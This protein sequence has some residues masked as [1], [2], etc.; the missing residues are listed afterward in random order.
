MAAPE[1]RVFYPD[2]DILSV[3]DQALLA[4]S[5]ES[6][7]TGRVKWEEI[8]RTS[9]DCF[10]AGFLYLAGSIQDQDLR[11]IG[12]VAWNALMQERVVLIV[13]SDQGQVLVNLGINPAIASVLALHD[14]EPRLVYNKR[15]R[16]RLLVEEM[17][18][19]V[20]TPAFIDAA[21]TRPVEALAQLT[22][23][24][25]NIRDIVHN[26]VQ[27]ASEATNARAQAA[28]AHFLRYAIHRHPEVSSTLSPNS[29]LAME[30]YPRGLVS[31]A[32]GMRYRGGSGQ[33]YRG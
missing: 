29:L 18:A 21:R 11:Q 20:A 26:R 9:R 17:A 5:S 16:G 19:V 14:S 22:A 31:L 30:T 3:F 24:S 15:S 4:R 33:I 27:D 2:D 1:E 28:R 25:S 23:L 12:T 6:L 32:A 13:T 10:S 7:A 8:V